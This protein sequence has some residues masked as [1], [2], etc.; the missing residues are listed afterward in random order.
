[1]GARRGGAP[2]AEGQ[3]MESRDIIARTEARPVVTHHTINV[4]GQTINYTATAGMLPIRN[5]QTGAV[6]AGMY[7][8]AY[9]KDGANPATRPLTFAFNGGPG[10]ATVWLHLGAFGPKKVRLNADGTNPPP[11]YT[12]EDNPNTLLDQTDLVFIDAIGT[13][14]SR[15]VTPQ[16]GAKFWGLDEDLNSFVEFI[17]LYLTRF[18]RM[19]SPKFLA[20]ESY[21]TTR[22]S[23]LSG[24]LADN[25]IALNGVVLLSSVLNFEY[26]S[27]ARGNDIGFINFIPTYAATAWYHKKLPADLQKLPVDQV[28]AM[29]EKWAANEYADAL[30][31][32]NNLTPAQRQATIDQMARLTGLPK[33]VID[34]NDLRVSLGTFDQELLRDQHLTVGRLDGRFTGF[35]PIGGGRGGG[36][37]VG[38]P[39]DI[40]IRNTFTPVLT[41]YT[42]RELNYKDED[43]YYILGGGIGRWNYPQNQY[44]TVVPNLERAFAKNPYMKL[45]VAEGYYDA[46]TPYFAVDYTLSHLSI[47]PRVAKD[48]ITVQ[49]FTAGH[50]MYIDA[51]S[52]K[53]LRSDLEKFYDHAVS[54]KAVP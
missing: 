41:D 21:G 51:P 42:R 7:Y 11:P 52:M 39:S 29:A 36:F 23:G 32:G 35:A 24:L 47:D 25:G 37:G 27:Q 40:S 22:A 31:K 50:M 4:R 43:L 14:Y 38:D 53:K 44:A 2:G 10:S 9:T 17:R 33:D 48:N 28:A 54:E 5:V 26:S 30:M 15:P 1:S 46:A 12:F 6:E 20:G 8:V 49:R 16:L 18:D 34:L 13:G 45:F 3:S 19:S